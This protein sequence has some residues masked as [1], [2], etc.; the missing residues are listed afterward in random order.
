MKSRFGSDR[1]PS[2]FGADSLTPA[3]WTRTMAA[4]A[5]APHSNENEKSENDGNPGSGTPVG[6]SPTSL[7]VATPAVPRMSSTT[8]GT[9]S[10]TS[11][12]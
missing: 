10:A 8:V 7:T 6:M 5:R 1:E 4:I 12:A 2:G 3:P 9:T 11:A